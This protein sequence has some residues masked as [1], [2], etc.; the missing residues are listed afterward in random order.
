MNDEF[1]ITT[2]TGFAQ[3]HPRRI[4]VKSEEQS[5]SY[6]D[7]EKKSNRVANFMKGKIK[8]VP[9]VIII[10]DR[11]PGLIISIIGLLKSGLVFVPLNPFFPGT[12]VKKMIEE[13]RAE[14][15]ITTE[16]YYEKFKQVIKSNKNNLK[17]LLINGKD[18]GVDPQENTFYLDSNIESDRLTFEPVFNKNCYIY[19]TSGSTGIP[20]GVLG[21]QESLVH[22]IQWEMKEFEVNESFNVSQMTPPS[23]DP[24]LR[25]IFLPLMVG[26]TS[27]IPSH[28]TLMNVRELIR[29]IEKD[30]ITLIHTVPSLFK[31]VVSEISNSNCLHSLKFILLAGELLRGRDIHRF[32][33]IFGDRIQLVN[34][35]GPTEATLA[36]LFYRIKPG[37]ANRASIPV[38]KPID[39]ARVLILDSKK[40]KCW[41]GQKGEIYIRTPFLSSGYYN[42]PRLNKKVFIKNPFSKHAND[43]IYK[44]GDL[45]RLLPDGNIE[46]SGRVDFQVK[47][48]GARIE[49][50]EIENRLLQHND[51]GEAVVTAKEEKNGDK[52]LCAY[53]VPVTGKKPDT[54]MLKEYLARDFPNYMVP[55]YFVFLDEMPLTANGKVD[56]S[57]LPDAKAYGLNLKND[58]LAPGNIIEERIAGIWQEVLH[59]E[60]V[61]INHNFFD[62]GGNSLKMMEVS[63]QLSKEFKK[64]IPIAKLFEHS[65]IRSLSTYLLEDNNNYTGEV[66]Q[67]SGKVKKRKSKDRFMQEIA[68]I[69]MSCKFPGAENIHEFW[70]ILKKGT[71]TISFFS[72]EELLNVGIN[73]GRLDRTNSVKAACLLPGKEYFDAA[74]FDYT[75]KEAAFLDP[76]IR[77]FHECAWEALEDGGI[78]PDSFAGKIGVYAG[79]IQN[80]D[81]EGRVLMSGKGQ[82]FGVFAASKLS[83]IRYL[84]TRL[85]YSLNL[86]GPSITMQTACSTSLVSIHMAWQSLLN[87]E[88]D[89]AIAGGVSLTPLKES[90]YVYEEG[91]VYSD[92]GHCRSF[93]ARAN[94]TIFGEGAGVVLLKPLET[95]IENRDHIYTVIKG[96][97]VNNDGNQKVAFTAPSVKGQVEVIRAALDIAGIEPRSIGYIETHGTATALGDPIEIEALT[98]VFNTHKQKSCKIG[99]V[100]SNFGHLDAAAG[101]AGFIKTVL[102]LKHRVIPPSLHFETPNPKINFEDTPFEVN[103]RLIEWKKENHPRRAGVSS[104]GMGGTN[105]H[106]ILEEAPQRKQSSESRNY[107]MILLSAKS[108]NSLNMGA[109]NLADFLKTNNDI[110]LADVAYT[111]QT[112]RKRFNYRRMF[113]CSGSDEAINALSLSRDENSLTNSPG[114]CRVYNC[115][116]TGENTPVIFM[117]PGQGSQYVNMGADLYRHEPVFREEV[118][119]CIH[120][121]RKMGCHIKD[122]LYPDETGS[123]FSLEDAN[124]KMDDVIYSGPIKFTIE[125]SLAKLLLKWGIRPYA[126]IGHSLG[127]YVAAHLS[128]VFTLEDALSLVV[129][130]GKLMEKIP[131]GAMMC[132]P[133]PEEELKPLLN[134]EISLAAVN[135]PS[136]CIVSG[137]VGAVDTFE[138][139]LNEKGYLCLRLNVPRAGHSKMMSPICKE[140]EKN[141]RKIK[142]NRPKIPYIAGLTGDWQTGAQATDPGYWARHLVETMRFSEGIKRLLEKS[143]AIFVPVGADSL[144]FQFVR[145]HQ[146][147]KSQNLNISLLKHPDGNIS[148]V[149]YMLNSLGRLW[150]HGVNVDWSE[151]YSHERRNFIPLPTYSFDR[152]YYWIDEV[153]LS[154]LGSQTKPL[155]EQDITRWFYMPIWTRTAQLNEKNYQAN[156]TGDKTKWLFLVDQHPLGDRLVKQLEQDINNEISIIRI[157]ENFKII[158]HDQ[159]IINPQNYNDYYQVFN[160]LNK[161]ARLPGKIVH[162]WGITHGN[163]EDDSDAVDE[164][165][166]RG[167][168]SLLYLTRAIA[169]LKS[170]GDFE[171]TVVT[172][173]I[174]YVTGHERLSPAWATVLGAVLVIPQE[175]RNI[176]CRSIDISFSHPENREAEEDDMVDQLKLDLLRVSPERF[177]AYRNGN[178]WVQQFNQIHCQENWISQP[179]WK[180]KGIYLITGGLGGIGFILARHLAET[181]QAKL[182][183]VGQTGLPGKEEWDNWL[184]AHDGTDR[185]SQKIQKVRQLEEL[186]SEVMEFKADVGNIEQMQMIIHKAEGKFGAINGIL[187]TAGGTKNTPSIELITQLDKTKCQPQFN[188]KIK[189]IMVLHRLFK[190]KTLDFCAS[191]SSISSFLGGLE[192][193]AYS[194]AN[195]FMDRFIEKTNKW[196]S[197]N[198]GSVDTQGDKN[199]EL[200]ISP[201]ECVKAFKYILGN[202]ASGQVIASEL[203]FHKQ[204]EYATKLK[205]HKNTTDTGKKKVIQQK[206]P[207]KPLQS[208]IYFAAIN[209]TEKKLLKIWQDLLGY[210]E[211]STNENFFELGGNSLTVIEV[212]RKVKEVFDIDISVV[213]V[214]RHPTIRLFADYLIKNVEAKEENE[215]SHQKEPDDVE[216]DLDEILERFEEI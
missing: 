70:D 94:G 194:A 78:V 14:W 103:T 104:L 100:K 64:E 107:H 178:Y 187:H 27:C 20:K 48:R 172:R 125:Y 149:H 143:N 122:I 82:S 152:N 2:I 180:Q 24:F 65:T 157:G 121:L 197:I 146:D 80:L 145:E 118:D 39:G 62:L 209:E 185:V 139:E 10:L 84:C 133:L 203:D 30:E 6:L 102:S 169:Q 26:G 142:L 53:V 115:T 213:E 128:G 170:A 93:D 114:N 109:K 92:D 56:R 127:E 110:K 113:T 88:C 132:V 119:Q 47:I 212:K 77:L 205:I 140:F 60:K 150:L 91:M 72:D 19:F 116:S 160:E 175:H 159:Y 50:A 181:Y 74:F 105:A 76:Q 18:D 124:K 40:Q 188:A 161:L 12:R 147:G 137:P 130:R 129:L 198:L 90:H 184:N 45:G 43:I 201:E 17:T 81:W 5:I 22:F 35:Y 28:D 23:F 191:T 87:R 165:L 79:A 190:D 73:P 154:S 59:L 216:E 52:Y 61:G 11:S 108:E 151:F 21:R 207:T 171:I 3:Q 189:G 163:D 176:Q 131:P 174:Q 7:L 135:T 158:D 214:F 156:K 29:W 210:E 155:K 200:S 204:Y 211:I 25:D 63:S 36:K 69:G 32:M 55:P 177:A 31:R 193:A 144:L 38:G 199:P 168:Y 42:D 101:V 195:I 215:I 16:E 97:A 112:R 68:V 208:N 202:I 89:A 57:T 49:L 111:L 183:L 167:F 51:V 153:D 196:I 1:P 164:V 67:K 206:K 173:D 33:E 71:E 134:D 166:D 123:D 186:G 46:L 15:V 37:D 66:S 9:H 192:Y 141:I 44:T 34:V 182:V 126:M 179:C 75:P 41:P 13:T 136:L 83:G 138:K 8:E 117:F 98:Q 4:A 162:L 58:Y 96:S 86:N 99:S 106:V 54:H 120:I 148:D 85:S 95:A